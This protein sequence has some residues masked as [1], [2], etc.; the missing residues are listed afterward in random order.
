MKRILIG[1]AYLIASSILAASGVIAD[2]IDRNGKY[3]DMN[4]IPIFI[5]LIFFV[6][7]I[8]Y[9]IAADKN[10]IKDIAKSINGIKDNHK[11]DIQ[12]GQIEGEK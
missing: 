11:A 6:I 9:F 7:A 8:C 12:S 4:I 5:A 3:S 1:V 10:E 2:A